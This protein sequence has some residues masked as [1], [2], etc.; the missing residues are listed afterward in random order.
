MNF[1]VEVDVNKKDLFFGQFMISIKSLFTN[2]FFIIISL[3][4][5]Y[6]ET[7]IKEHVEHRIVVFI[8]LTIILYLFMHLFFII[9]ILLKCIFSK[10]KD[11]NC[12][13]KFSFDE[14][15][16]TKISKNVK[17]EYSYTALTKVLIFLDSMYIGITPK[18]YHIAPKRCFKTEE[19]FNKLYDFLKMKL[20]T[21]ME[22]TQ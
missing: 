17:S 1:S 13:C 19:D 8:I 5:S 21:N 16:M 10:E 9:I 20:N 18:Q 14:N 4:L 2:V 12:C 6:N 11:S 15:I 22:N 7:F 3:G